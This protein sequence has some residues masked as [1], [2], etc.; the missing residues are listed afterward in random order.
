MTPVPLAR[1]TD[2]SWQQQLM[3]LLNASLEFCTEL[4]R[5]VD[6]RPL[7]AGFALEDAATDSPAGRQRTAC[8]AGLAGH[9]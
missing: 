2:R 9:S 6:H 3:T 1:Q 4:R 8:R 5:S 7:L